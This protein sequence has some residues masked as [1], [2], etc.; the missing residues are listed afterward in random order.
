MTD[1]PR[2][3]FEDDTI[4]VC[5]DGDGGWMK[6]PFPDENSHRIPAA[7]FEEYLRAEAALD[8]VSERISRWTYGER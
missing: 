3:S 6:D 1:E 5:G 4:P 2:G 7:L 8:A